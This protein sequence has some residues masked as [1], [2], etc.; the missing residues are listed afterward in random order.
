MSDILLIVFY[1]FMS[2]LSLNPTVCNL[3]IRFTYISHNK[4]KHVPNWICIN[5]HSIIYFCFL[6]QRRRTSIQWYEKPNCHWLHFHLHSLH[7]VTRKDL[8]ILL[9]EWFLNLWA[10]LILTPTLSVQA[11]FTGTHGC[12]CLWSSV[13]TF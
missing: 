12:L 11:T 4:Y 5:L 9:P 10:F 8:Q 13:S 2:F 1:V 6:S 3:W 7:P